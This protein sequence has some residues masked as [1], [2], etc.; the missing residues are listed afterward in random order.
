MDYAKLGMAIGGVF[1]FVFLYEWLFHGVVLKKTYTA[2]QSLW[3][4]PKDCVWQALISGQALL[5]VIFSLFYALCGAGTGL[6]AGLLFG[7]MLG[8]V[9]A[10][11]HLMMYAVV[12]YP[13][14]LVMAW[15]AGGV[16]E[17]GVCGAIV[18]WIYVVV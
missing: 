18:G 3:R 6:E 13:P 14:K 2:S 1:V 17:M 15:I 4:L 8:A 10:P 5:A 9:M 16:L 7:V 11:H 12:P